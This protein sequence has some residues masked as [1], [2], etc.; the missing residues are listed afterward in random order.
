MALAALHPTSEGALIIIPCEVE[1]NAIIP[2]HSPYFLWTSHGIHSHLPP[3]PTRAPNDVVRDLQAIVNRA[4]D[5]STTRGTKTSQHT[6]GAT[7]LL[8]SLATL[9]RSGFLR[10]FLAAKAVESIGDLH[11]SFTKKDRIRAMISLAKL[12]LF[13]EGPHFAGVQFEFEQQKRYPEKVGQLV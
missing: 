13:P 3:P 2:D 1:F 11:L 6:S 7:R 12:S 8:T 10:S 5:A 4:T 9:L